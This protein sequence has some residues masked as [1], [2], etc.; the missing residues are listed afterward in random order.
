MNANVLE[1]FDNTKTLV[2]KKELLNIRGQLDALNKVLATIEFDLKGNVLAVSESFCKL[3]GYS[4]RD[5]V[6]NH[7]S[8]FV[9]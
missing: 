3:T 4:Q 1:Y 6:G 5:I 7:H 9:A 8:M 2:N